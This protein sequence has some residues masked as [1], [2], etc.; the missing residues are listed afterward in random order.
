[1]G[2]LT[3]FSEELERGTTNSLRDRGCDSPTALGLTESDSASVEHATKEGAGIKSVPSSGGGAEAWL[4]AE[5]SGA[6][7]ALVN[8]TAGSK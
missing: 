1:M 2:E 8:L 5:I 7:T 6:G 4:R 3:N